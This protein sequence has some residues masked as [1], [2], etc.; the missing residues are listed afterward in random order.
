MEQAADLRPSRFANA[1]W[2]GLADHFT[3]PEYHV[4]SPLANR[5]GLQLGRAFV[6]K[7]GH[8]RRKQPVDADLQPYVDAFERDGCLTVESFLPEDVF[9]Q[10]RAECRTLH[11]EGLFKSEVV[12]DN[13]VVEESSSVKRFADRMPVTVEHVARNSFLR[14]LGPALTRLEHGRPKEVQVSYMYKAVDAPKPK[15]LVGSNYIHADL[16]YQSVKAWLFLDD[17]DERNG[18][19]VF[20]KGSHKLRPARLAYEYEASVRVAK[21]KSRD[22]L[23]RDVPYGLVR[24]PTDQQLRAMGIEETV[25]GGPANT[26]IVATVMGFHRRGEFEEGRRREQIQIKFNDRPAPK[27]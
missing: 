4:G 11:D 26:L 19:F 6:M 1:P 18:A 10:V 2:K 14:R 23:R 24:K 8:R 22:G 27:Q 20:A 3:A 25:L 7:A 13:S 9:E 17:V 16:H 12:E 21:I 5:L 15:R